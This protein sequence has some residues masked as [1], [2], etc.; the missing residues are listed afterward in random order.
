MASVPVGS[1][2]FQRWMDLENAYYYSIKILGMII[3]KKL[4]FV[5]LEAWTTAKLM[6]ILPCLVYNYIMYKTLYVV[7]V[8]VR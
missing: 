4:P 5:N 2:Q 8:K 1:A 6:I 3:E 7:F